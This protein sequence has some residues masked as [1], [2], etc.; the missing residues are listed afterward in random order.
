M[1]QLCR[2]PK[3]TRTSEQLYE[4]LWNATGF[5]RLADGARGTRNIGVARSL[6][7]GNRLRT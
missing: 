2:R 7:E 4:I 6:S 3:I 1:N 5:A